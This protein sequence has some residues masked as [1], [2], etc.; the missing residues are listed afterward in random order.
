[1]ARIWLIDDWLI[2]PSSAVAASV[3]QAANESFVDALSIG[4][5]AAAGFIGIALLGPPD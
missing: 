1:V 2:A 5:L 4:Y 3:T